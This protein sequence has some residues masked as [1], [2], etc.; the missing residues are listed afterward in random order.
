MQLIFEIYDQIEARV[1]TVVRVAKKLAAMYNSDNMSTSCII[2]TI[3]YGSD[4]AC[5]TMPHL[6]FTLHVISL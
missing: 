6:I 4:I 5:I 1:I 2:D 3:V